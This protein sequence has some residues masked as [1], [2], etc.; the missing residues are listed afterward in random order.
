[1]GWRFGRLGYRFLFSR[2]APP[3]EQSAGESG[4]G[5]GGRKDRREG[6]QMA[7]VGPS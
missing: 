6:R 1:M 2:S 5:M 4:K 7:G 3:A